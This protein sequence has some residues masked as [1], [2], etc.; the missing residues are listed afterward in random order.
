MDQTVRRRYLR[1]LPRELVE[2]AQ[3]S[4]HA[5]GLGEVVTIKVHNPLI[6]Y[7]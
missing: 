1:E 4:V 3:L 7:P 2:I 6:I 5:D